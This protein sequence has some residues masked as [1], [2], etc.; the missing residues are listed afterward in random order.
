MVHCAA[1]NCT[2]NQ[3]TASK[4]ISFHR[5]PSNKTQRDIW[6]QRIKRDGFKPT[7]TSYLC[8]RHF[9]ANSYYPFVC[10]RKRRD[11]KKSAVPTIFNFP[12]I[13][14]LPS[15][16]GTRRRPAPRVRGVPP[17][18]SDPDKKPW[19]EN[20]PKLQVPKTNM[21]H[22]AYSLKEPRQII[23]DREALLKRIERQQ[24]LIKRLQKSNS[25]QKKTIRILRHTVKALTKTSYA[26]DTECKREY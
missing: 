8:S 6:V 17:D 5:F 1:I 4:D 18:R 12:D 2:N 13:D 9:S 26:S 20:E 15:P 22:C 23:Q 10:D 19:L 3:T 14:G 11:L 24:K 16:R 25:K 7:R 21:D